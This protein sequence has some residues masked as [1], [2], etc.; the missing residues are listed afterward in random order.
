MPGRVTVTIDGVEMEANAGELV[1][2]VAQDHGIYIP[3]FCWHERMKPVGM[4]RMCLVEIEGQRGLPPAC[5]ATVTDGM[6]VHTQTPGVKKA[7]EG[8]LE[9][10]LINHPLDCPV[11]D[12]GG[13]C[14]LQ[15]LTFGFGPGESRFVEEKRHYAKPIAISELVLLD[16][17][18]C[19][20]CARCTRFADEVA[21][22]PLIQFVER[23]AEMQVLT[24][25]S[26]PFRSYFSGNTVQICPVG[27]LL[28]APYRFR[29]RPWDLSSVETSC[30]MCSLNCRIALQSSA[31]RLVRVLGVDS[32]PLNHGWVCDKGRFGFDYVHHADRIVEPQVR[33]IDG[34]RVEAT[35]PEALDAAA[36][37]LATAL[38]RGGPS[39]V[40][41]IGGARGTNEDAYAW[42]RLAKG[43]LK[44]D[45]VDCQLGD[46]LPAD[47]VNGLPRAR[48]SDCDSARAIVLLAPDLKEELAVTYLRVKRA[49]VDLKVPLI[50]ISPVG[51]GMTRYAE[52]VLRHLPGEAAAVAEQLSALVDAVPAPATA[53]EPPGTADLSSA[54]PAAMSPASDQTEPVTVSSATGGADLQL[55][56]AAELLRA[57]SDDERPVI[58]ILGRPSLAE[59][60]DATV[61]A[62][63][64]L[65]NIPGVRFLSALRRS[66]VHGG[67]DLGLAP[68]F[69]PGR[70]TL[71]AGRAWFEAAWGGAPAERGLDTAGILAAAADGRLGALV[72]VGA[73][74][75]S[76]FPDRDLAR[77]AL[78][79]VPFIV[80]VDA[81]PTPSTELA[82]VFLPVALAGEKRG[83][84]TNLE[85]RLL[86]LARKVTPPGTAMEDWRIAVELAL[87]LGTDFDL[88][89]VD[90]VTDE[91]AR[92]APAHSGADTALLRRAADGAVIPLGEL[93]D[94]VLGGPSHSISPTADSDPGVVGGP[95]ESLIVMRG[96][97]SAYGTA[98]PGTGGG[99]ATLAAPSRSGAH[100][101]EG[102]TAPP[103]YR[104]DGSGPSPASR[105]G[106]AGD[107]LRLWSGRKL[108]NPGVAVTHSEAVATLA[109]VDC[110]RLHP[111]EV[112]RL[113]ISAGAPVRVTS[114]RGSV[115][116]PAVA[117][118]AVPAG[119]AWMPPGP[120][121]EVTS[122]GTVTV[123]NVE[124]AGG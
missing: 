55:G 115:T 40:A 41:V 111:D 52:V 27:A 18:R 47:V 39:S 28:A 72:L 85:G 54:A 6:V 68:G 108:Y 8:V 124:T 7:Q 15:D 97:S 5:T 116:L 48:L 103:L 80:A 51:S 63:A 19:I 25:P 87:R 36:A 43:V 65:R 79:N 64:A 89:A 2:K 91:I 75:L 32:E 102:M 62:A 122:V 84:S 11:C 104:W 99:T 26:Q 101:P 98:P 34:T 88:E 82:H 112:G 21:G 93:E 60:A 67:L 74:P 46:G 33:G 38:D 95:I 73:D 107:G 61:A 106:G 69:L 113:G 71:D 86:R 10:L 105:A 22:D 20:L 35:W 9:F 120:A 45:N 94:P 77:R 3:R 56:A 30:Q 44:T 57:S 53:P 24:F 50:E 16:R 121:A 92:L 1:I 117:D 49:A 66:N 13:E 83:T 109:A 110:V 118:N 12:R 96:S 58:V 90:E 4:C 70:V 14:P 17:E 114:S 31:D 81:F 59:P 123:V 37:G 29:A 119:V 76:D 23:G 42:A 100:P 78:A